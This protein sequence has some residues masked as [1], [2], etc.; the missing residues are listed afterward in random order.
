MGMR[1][2]KARA[3]DGNHILMTFSPNPSIL[4]RGRLGR[5][6]QAVS[7]RPRLLRFLPAVHDS[8]TTMR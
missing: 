2:K 6:R 7:V 1:L 4:P 5:H 3:N 8:N